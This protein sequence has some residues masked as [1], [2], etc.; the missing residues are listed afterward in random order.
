MAR[1]KNLSVIREQVMPQVSSTFLKLASGTNC[2]LSTGKRKEDPNDHNA[3]GTGPSEPGRR[4]PGAAGDRPLQR[5][6]GLGQEVLAG[7]PAVRRG[8]GVESG[9]IFILTAM[10]ALVYGLGKEP[11]RKRA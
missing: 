6:A 5:P 8:S 4:Y 9:R 11:E 2:T 7:T 10:V 1:L 3:L